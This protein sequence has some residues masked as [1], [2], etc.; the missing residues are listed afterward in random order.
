LLF[1]CARRWWGL[2]AAVLAVLLLTTNF[3]LFAFMRLAL[4]ETLMVLLGVAGLS[5]ALL[6]S[7]RWWKTRAVSAGA[8]LGLAVLTKATGVFV[9]PALL[10]A[11]WRRGGT[12]RHRV[13]TVVLLGVSAGVPVMAHQTIARRYFPDD[14]G[15]FHRA[16]VVSR[17]DPRPAAIVR[18]VVSR[19]RGP[20]TA[21]RVLYPAAV[22]VA[23]AALV[24]PRL[25][26]D[27][28]VGSLAVW[29]VAYTVL[30]APMNYHPPRW[31]LSLYIP[32]AMVGA[33]VLSD[34]W[35]TRGRL[36]RAAAGCAVV[37]TAGTGLLRIGAYLVN[38]QHTFVSA[39]A[40]ISARA[41]ADDPSPVLMGDLA[42]TIALETGLP[43]VNA[44]QGPGTA[45]ERIARYHP[46]HFVALGAAPLPPH[47]FD[48]VELRPLQHYDVFGNYYAGPVWLYRVLPASGAATSAK[49]R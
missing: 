12:L 11:L 31:F 27:P 8:L 14:V 19:L 47:Q 30:M 48:G 29:F 45:A 3:F 2:P 41:H 40:D 9:G 33:L 20:L 25:R 5:A 23:A 32:L 35:P 10:Y 34:V 38:T 49:Q 18:R 39:A 36:A 28:L 1:C 17:V 7:D 37:L 22:L 21:D 43:A 15:Y 46:T 24:R 13:W 26:H 4:P 42:Y 6:I 44:D 16:V